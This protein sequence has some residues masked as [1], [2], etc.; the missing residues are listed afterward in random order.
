MKFSKNFEVTRSRVLGHMKKIELIKGD[1]F[2]SL[3]KYI[4][5][6]PHLVISLLYLD[7]DLY[8]PT[9]DTIKLLLNR[10][11]K[12]GVICFDELNHQDY[13]GE[14]IATMEEIGIPN[15]QLHRF[16]F[17]TTMSYTIIQ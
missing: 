3:P 5:Q 17:G 10:I 4:K 16:S 8:K 6:N 9:K 7:L 14:T 1:I 15:L 12:G 2:K 13:P 11:P